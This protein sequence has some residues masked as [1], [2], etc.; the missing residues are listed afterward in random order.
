MAVVDQLL[1]GQVRVALDLERHPTTLAFVF[2]FLHDVWGN[3]S[4]VLYLVGD[5]LVL[6][7]WLVEDGFN[8]V[9]VEVGD[10]DGL[11]QAVIHQLL[12]SLHTHFSSR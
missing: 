1:L 11:D 12:H 7:A 9:F 4:L 6:E 10:T 8:L 2:V 5:G 3:H